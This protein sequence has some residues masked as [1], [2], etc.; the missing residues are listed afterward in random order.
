MCLCYSVLRLPCDYEFGS[1]ITLNS[2]SGQIQQQKYAC[3]IFFWSMAGAALQLIR[4]HVTSSVSQTLSFAL[5]SII[6]SVHCSYC[7]VWTLLLTLL[8]A[9]GLDHIAEQILSYVDAASLMAA[10]LVC[11]EWRRVIADGSLWRKLIEHK[12]LT[13]TLWKGLA[14]RKGWYVLKTFLYCVSF[15]DSICCGTCS[16]FLCISVN[17]DK[18][19]LWTLSCAE[20]SSS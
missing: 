16:T 20:E 4:C 17:L 8:L 13:D 9:R 18:F 19:G 2:F 14:E 7:G 15:V 3:R 1:W 6:R 10:E 11:K 5:L 12:V